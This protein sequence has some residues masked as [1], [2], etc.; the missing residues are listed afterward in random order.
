VLARVGE[1]PVA[2]RQRSVLATAFHPE[3]VSES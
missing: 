3:V 2:V 1:H